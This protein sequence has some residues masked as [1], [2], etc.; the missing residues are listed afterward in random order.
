MFSCKKSNAEMHSSKK[1][2]GMLSLPFILLLCF[3]RGPA[4]KLFC[5]I[6][7]FQSN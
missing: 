3:V 6:D 5:C 1:S 7:H 2:K 4:G